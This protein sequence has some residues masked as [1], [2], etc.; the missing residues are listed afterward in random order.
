MNVIVNGSD[1]FMVYK[2]SWI[3]LF[4]VKKMFNNHKC[5]GSNWFMVYRSLWINLFIN[6]YGLQRFMDKIKLRFMINVRL[7]IQLDS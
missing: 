2:S 5:Y 7:K 6:I 1:M 4:M 3:E